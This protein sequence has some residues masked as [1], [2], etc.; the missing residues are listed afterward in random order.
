M[1]SS[2]YSTSCA[3]R[4]SIPSP[5]VFSPSAD[6]SQNS[7]SFDYEKF[8]FSTISNANAC[9]SKRPSILQRLPLS[10][11]KYS[12]A[13]GHFEQKLNE[14]AYGRR[15]INRSKSYEV[16]ARKISIERQSVSRYNKKNEDNDNSKKYSGISVQ[17]KASSVLDNTATSSSNC[18]QKLNLDNG[19]NR[20]FR[21]MLAENKTIMNSTIQYNPSF[22][23]P[24]SSSSW[25]TP[26]CNNFTQASASDTF[27]SQQ[28]FM[29]RLLQAHQIVDE[30]LKSR[31]L[32]PEDERNF[33][34]Y[35]DQDPIIEEEIKVDF[36]RRSSA[37]DSGL[38]LDNDSDHS[39]LEEIHEIISECQDLNR[40]ETE[41]QIVQ[42]SFNFQRNLCFQCLFIESVS[43]IAIC[44]SALLN[45]VN[46]TQKRLYKSF[47][48]IS[49]ENNKSKQRNVAKP[50]LARQKPASPTKSLQRFEQCSVIKSFHNPYRSYLGISII[51]Q[52]SNSNWISRRV[53]RKE[54]KICKILHFNK[55]SISSQEALFVMRRKDPLITIFFNVHEPQ[56]FN[57]TAK[58]AQ[59]TLHEMKNNND[60][61][62][63]TALRKALPAQVHKEENKIPIVAK[64]SKNF[65]RVNSLDSNFLE[66]LKNNQNQQDEIRLIKNNLRKVDFNKTV[67]KE[68]LKIYCIQDYHLRTKKNILNEFNLNETQQ[69][70]GETL[71][72]YENIRRID[73]TNIGKDN[74]RSNKIKQITP[75][76]TDGNSSII[77]QHQK[78]VELIKPK[79]CEENKEGSRGLK[80]IEKVDSREI[81]KVRKER[82]HE[83]EDNTKGINHAPAKLTQKK[84]TSISKNE[85]IPIKSLANNAKDIKTGSVG[86]PNFTEISEKMDRIFINE[87]RREK[88]IPKPKAVIRF[89]SPIPFKFME[90]NPIALS[91]DRSFSPIKFIQRATPKN[92][93]L[94]SEPS[95]FDNDPVKQHL[96]GSILKPTK[97]AVKSPPSLTSIQPSFPPQNRFG[98][99]LKRVNRQKNE[100]KCGA[101]TNL[102]P[103]EPW[104]P[105]WRR[106]QR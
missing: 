24:S 81:N 48:V 61:S 85:E 39:T 83:K 102:T 104:I 82:K 1:S 71:V 25:K 95:F 73:K 93:K 40:Q 94:L 101:I 65:K 21:T 33:L 45:I 100:T 67:R 60:Q 31:G 64:I 13:E 105:K 35:W 15:K 5:L 23:G 86:S 75:R 98:V 78:T 9:K 4:R 63:T 87:F 42:C 59:L 18:R 55:F 20:S 47:E 32:Q 12:D 26:I 89:P 44:S 17:N 99:V 43:P 30:L 16:P 41:S 96:T 68:G 34:R 22:K 51:R 77:N 72:K 58:N 38:S 69:E 14:E 8:S 11:Q 7:A 74:E 97:K 91:Q 28:F 54:E 92:R 62:S 70:D 10:N 79:E 57:S 46:F 66:K 90:N 27:V 49:P 103:K 56:I 6:Q 37:S 80:K 88:A 84:S 2:R 50:K 53:R 76:R 36:S 52:I 106:I 29:Q 19:T 3:P